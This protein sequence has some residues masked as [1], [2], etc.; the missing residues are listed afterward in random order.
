MA[1]KVSSLTESGIL[2]GITVVMA[3]IAMYVPL[4]G[5]LAVLLWPLPMILLL[6]RHG[7]KWALMSVATAIVVTAALVEPMASLRLAVSFAPTGLAL[8]IGYRRHWSGVKIFS[9]ATIASII[10]K[11]LGLYIVF[12]ITGIEPFSGQLEL[13]PQQFEQSVSMYQSMGM[14]PEQIEQARQNFM[15]NMRMISLLLPMVVLIMGILDTALNFWAGGIMLRR[16][17]EP[18]PVFPAFTEWRLPSFFAYLYAFSIL[19]MY[20]GDTHSIP[21]LYKIAVNMNMAGTVAGLVQG[22]SV[23]QA[24][25]SHYK[26]PSLMSNIVMVLLVLS[27]IGTQLIVFTGLFD[28]VFDYRRRMGWQK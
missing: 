1:T 26:W 6:V 17:G 24:A 8:G 14:S 9:T 11:G 10:A 22:V 21:L 13:M 5:I 3:I 27:G 4:V 20:W 28:T 19:G 15:E 23:Y 16:F 2:A 18:V 12:L 25:V 7:L